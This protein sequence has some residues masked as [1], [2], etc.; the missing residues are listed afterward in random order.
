M[1]TVKCRMQ[2][3]KYRI[4]LAP[5]TIGKTQ[6][7]KVGSCLCFLLEFFGAFGAG[8]DD[9]ALAS[10]HADGL[11][12]AGTFVVPVLPILDPLE[13]VQIVPVFPIAL[14]SVPGE[15]TEDR[16][17]H[18]QV[19]QAREDQIQQRKPCK[20]GQNAKDQTDA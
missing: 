7:V 6:P 8:D 14:V 20:H 11:P 19:R 4:I 18:K 9:L 13:E 15:H 1:R 3:A 10:G 12:A 17:G 5:P 16:P 2:N